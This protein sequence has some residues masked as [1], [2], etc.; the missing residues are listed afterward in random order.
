MRRNCGLSSEIIYRLNIGQI[1]K[2]KKTPG[3]IH[4]TY[5][6]KM[7]KEHYVERLRNVYIGQTHRLAPLT[8]TNSSADLS[9]LS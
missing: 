6:G 5:K 4:H 7:C 9:Q 2:K 1:A 8:H 3:D